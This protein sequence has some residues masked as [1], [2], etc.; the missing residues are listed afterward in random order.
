M[1]C[2][3]CNVDMIYKPN[4]SEYTY[5]PHRHDIVGYKVNYK[6]TKP[7]LLAAVGVAK[8]REEDAYVVVKP[9]IHV[10][11]KCGLVLHKIPNEYIDFVVNSHE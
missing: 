7:G 4:V 5:V 3:S 11:P 6:D 9:Q 10:C 1:R 8:P 2:P